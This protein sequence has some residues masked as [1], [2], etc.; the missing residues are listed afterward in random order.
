MLEASTT[1]DRPVPN[2]SQITSCTHYNAFFV[3]YYVEN[4]KNKSRMT[5][6]MLL[7]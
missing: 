6:S 3:D 5:Y 1:H 2:K 7:K 4:T